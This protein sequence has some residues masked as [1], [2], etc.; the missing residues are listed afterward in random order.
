MDA[1]PTDDVVIGLYRVLADLVVLAQKAQGFHWNVESPAFWSYHG[2]FG[3]VYVVVSGDIDRVAEHI[4][5]LG[6]KTPTTLLAFTK[7]SNITESQ[8]P[9]TAAE[10]V[11][12]LLADTVIAAKQ[13]ATVLANAA[14]LGTPGGESTVQVLGD[15]LEHNGRCQYLLRS[16]R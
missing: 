1:T 2:L 3:E 16:S 6:S 14:A 4:R 8:L 13:Q 12:E 11:A 10:Q 9:G 15:L 5:A 7:L